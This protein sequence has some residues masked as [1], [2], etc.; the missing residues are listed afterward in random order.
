[1]PREL[2]VAG[3]YFPSLLLALFITMP[4]YWVVDGMLARLGCYRWVWH[5]DLFRLCLFIIMF[6]GL[7]LYLY[8]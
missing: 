5:I 8:A 6:G 2:D 1:M 7:G 3:V 4:V